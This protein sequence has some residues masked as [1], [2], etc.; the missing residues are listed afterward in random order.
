VYDP[1]SY[2]EP[3]SLT[4]RT[5]G[6]DSDGTDPLDREYVRDSVE[7]RSEWVA[8]ATL[9]EEMT[10]LLNRGAYQEDDVKTEIDSYR[11]E[12]VTNVSDGTSAG[13]T[14]RTRGA[15]RSSRCSMRSAA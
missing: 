11:P 15:T 12:T 1:S 3:A 4:R 2:G 7:A 9:Y 14:R 5:P 10:S 6:S 13:L 8:S